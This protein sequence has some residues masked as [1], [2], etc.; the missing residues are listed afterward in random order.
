MT[1]TR[2]GK[3]VLVFIED[4]ICEGERVKKLTRF[5]MIDGRG[6][7]R[8][9]CESL[10]VEELESENTDLKNQLSAQNKAIIEMSKLVEQVSA[11]NVE[12][13]EKIEAVYKSGINGIGYVGQANYQ[14]REDEAMRHLHD[15]MYNW[16]PK[17]TP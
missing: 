16:Q 14:S 6:Y 9:M 17:E 1:C 7:I 8:E 5:D 3:Q 10:D 13:K 15:T 11:E 2:C 4:H 12:L